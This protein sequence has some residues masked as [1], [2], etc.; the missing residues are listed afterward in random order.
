MSSLAP[1][2]SGRWQASAAIMCALRSRRR[3]RRRWLLC[4]S[5]LSDERASGRL[6][7]IGMSLSSAAEQSQ[8]KILSSSHG[9][10]LGRIHS[11][12]GR[13]A[14]ARAGSEPV[15]SGA[16]AKEFKKKIRTVQIGYSP[17]ARPR[18][19]TECQCRRVGV[20]AGGR[21]RP[22]KTCR[23]CKQ[24]ALRLQDGG[25]SRDLDYE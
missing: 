25:R 13:L 15:V 17:L 23:A 24:V 4:R 16:R 3:R 14:D 19:P 1:A 6:R 12:A 10:L 8:S 5:R 7:S 22:E 21:M 11:D 18:G 9:P 2:S 20:A